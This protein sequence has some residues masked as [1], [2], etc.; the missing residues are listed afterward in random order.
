MTTGIGWTPKSRIQVLRERLASMGITVT[1]KRN[2]YNRLVAIAYRGEEKVG[3]TAIEREEDAEHMVLALLTR[4]PGKDRQR[5]YEERFV[6]R[7]RNRAA[8]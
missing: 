7:A 3:E 4:D 1:T 2:D 6:R 8:K 5:K